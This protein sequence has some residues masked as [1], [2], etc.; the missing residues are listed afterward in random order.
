MN[1]APYHIIKLA[2][3]YLHYYLTAANGKGHGIHSPFVYDFVTKVL[4][5]RRHYYAYDKVEALRD[6]L[7]NDKRI[8]PVEDL[9]AGSG[10][11]SA[12]ERSIASIARNAAKPKKL[13]QLLFRIVDH[14]QPGVCIELGTSLGLTSAY[15]AL[16][17]PKGKLF[18]L[19]GSAAI[20]GVAKENLLALG[21]DNVEL[22]KGN[23][24]DTLLPLLHGLQSID[25]AFI[26]GNHRY[27]PTMRYFGQLMEKIHN[28][29][30]LVFDDIHWS[31]GMEKAWEEIKA[32]PRVTLSI[33]LFFLGIVIFSPDIKVKQHFT[34]R[35]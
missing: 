11:D 28:Q 33:D 4:D 32:D 14:Y 8:I 30:M 7:M 20:A 13:G 1:Q 26:D 9:G 29:T 17:N 27:E 19:E 15:L 18:T 25:L 22:L 2:K 5:D 23:F 24:D 12:A 35:F 34:V 6:R 16:G 21:I 10:R 31:E 3:K